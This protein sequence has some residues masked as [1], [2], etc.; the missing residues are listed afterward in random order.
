[1]PRM[2]PQLKRFFFVHV[3]MP[4]LLASSV[5]SDARAQS[6]QTVQSL[7]KGRLQIVT[8]TGA[9]EIF[10]RSGQDGL[11]QPVYTSRAPGATDAL[12]HRDTMECEGISARINQSEGRSISGL[13]SRPTIRF[14]NS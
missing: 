8:P 4:E 2:W 6:A 11:A 12:V 9:R 5:L 7:P 1:M 14:H 3:V 10:T 13:S